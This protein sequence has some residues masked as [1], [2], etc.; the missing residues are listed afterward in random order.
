MVRRKKGPKRPVS[1]NQ[2]NLF[3]FSRLILKVVLSVMSIDSNVL[4]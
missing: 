3:C 2:D 1:R 4:T